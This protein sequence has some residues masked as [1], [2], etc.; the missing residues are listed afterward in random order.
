M[1]PGFLFVELLKQLFLLRRGE[2]NI[3]PVLAY[4]RKQS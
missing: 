2:P 3:A 4:G 1:L